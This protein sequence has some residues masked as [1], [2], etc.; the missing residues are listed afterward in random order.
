MSDDTKQPRLDFE[1]LAAF[2]DG[3]LD[4]AQRQRICELIAADPRLVERLEGLHQLREA[5]RRSLI[6]AA[7]ATPPELRAAIEG[8]IASASEGAVDSKKAFSPSMK[9]S[10][11]SQ[12]GLE[13]LRRS[14]SPL[15]GPWLRR[16]LSAAALVSLAAMVFVVTQSVGGAGLSGHG[17]AV[18][19]LS[20]GTVH[21]LTREH[22]LCS[23]HPEH[24][25]RP[26]DFPAAD[27]DLS[28]KVDKLLG[29]SKCP[30][31]D[32][33]SIGYHCSGAGLCTTTGVRG[34]HLVYRPID[35]ASRLDPLSVWIESDRRRS[36]EAATQARMPQATADDETADPVL[37]WHSDHL[38]FYIVSDTAKGVG[39]AARLLARRTPDPSRR[40]G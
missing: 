29:E 25:G 33:T 7:P 16:A 27:S 32:L 9:G 30:S 22:T 1:L 14:L 11:A 17:S 39:D 23:E 20:L 6:G 13:R 18:P 35:P 19:V 8:L 28:Q 15:S 37:F 40:R 3:E 4:A 5:T 38:V 21:S 26:N 2:A 31:L 10:S 36:P 24:L 12:S 34:V